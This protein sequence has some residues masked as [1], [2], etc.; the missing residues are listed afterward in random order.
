MTMT[1]MTS[2]QSEQVL[3]LLQTF[4]PIEWSPRMSR[5]HTISTTEELRHIFEDFELE[6]VL[7]GIRSLARV[8]DKPPTLKQIIE[9][10][11]RQRGTS[12]EASGWH[13]D[14]YIA[15]WRTVE[16]DGTEYDY[17]DAFTIK[18][19]DD[20]RVEVPSGRKIKKAEL[21]RQH[22]LRKEAEKYE[23][24]QESLPVLRQGV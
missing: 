1:M 8:V 11:H 20:G 9:A 14:Q 22:I 10:A 6:Q 21:Y 7:E 23:P 2:E 18:V 17:V 13:W 4:W 15:S 16:I 19:F 5:R 24:T 3:L 12:V